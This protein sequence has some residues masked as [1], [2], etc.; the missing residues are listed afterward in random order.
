[1]PQDMSMPPGFGR[2]KAAH[3]V[4]SKTLQDLLRLASSDFD[5][6][7]RVADC[8]VE[9]M[10]RPTNC[11]QSGQF[12]TS[13]LELGLSFPGPLVRID[14]MRDAQTE[15]SGQ[16][17]IRPIHNEVSEHH[18]LSDAL[19]RRGS[20]LSERLSKI[21]GF[22]EG[23][24]RRFPIEASTTAGADVGEHFGLSPKIA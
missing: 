23:V 24:H 4:G 15:C 19:E 16:D 5:S 2:S 13:F 21:D 9:V 12:E 20:L 22:F 11:A 3:F 6:R 7:L 14:V 17:H 18:S 1:P 10:R 8:R